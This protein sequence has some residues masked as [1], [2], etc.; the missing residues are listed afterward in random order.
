[1]SDSA[2]I[3]LDDANRDQL[4]HFARAMLNLDVNDKCNNATLRAKILAASPG[5]THI[6]VPHTMATVIEQAP[7]A[8]A[9]AQVEA[10]ASTGKLSTHFRDDPKVRLM[11]QETT[12]LTRAKDVQVAV[13]GDVIIIRRGTEVDIP[14]RFYLALKDAVEQVARD[15]DEINPQT[16]LPIK[17]WV[18]RHSYPFSVFSMPSQ[19]E[20]DAWNKR[21]SNMALV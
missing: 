5:T 1:M 16:G 3:P 7:A 18:E 13:Q 20:I 11:V 14:Y 2:K 12:E 9:A 21:M 6:F 19:T 8:A 15:T 10:K 17:E 4:F